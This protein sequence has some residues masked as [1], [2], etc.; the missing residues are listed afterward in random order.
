VPYRYRYRPLSAAQSNYQQSKD[1]Y[2]FSMGPVH[3][4][5]L[6][7][8][9]PSDPSSAQY[10]FVSQDLKSLD[11]K[12]YPWVVV[13]VHRMMLSYPTTYNSTISSDM[14]VMARLQADFFQLFY[15]QQVDLV[16]S[17]HNHAY[18]RSCPIKPDKTCTTYKNGTT[19][20]NAGAP[21]F[22]LSGNG[23]AG[24]TNNFDFNY[25]SNTGIRNYMVFARQ[26]QNGYL[27]FKATKTRLAMEAVS[28]DDRT[29]FD[30]LTLRKTM[31]KI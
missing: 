30:S 21:V 26:F 5:V 13:G 25:W 10:A 19:Y 24:F 23:G 20:T 1:Y 27:R 28:D 22:V 18:S 16:V 2:S 3:F 15:D 6:D 31:R 17:G 11:R 8:E 29:T 4:I 12:Q 7:G 9:T 14:T